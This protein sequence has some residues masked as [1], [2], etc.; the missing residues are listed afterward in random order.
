M[1]AASFTLLSSLSLKAQSPNEL[2]ML[3]AQFSNRPYSLCLHLQAE[4]ARELALNWESNGFS[5]ALD[6]EVQ[7]MQLIVFDD[8]P[9][10]CADLQRLAR[11]LVR[12]QGR[13]LSPTFQSK[14]DR[15]TVQVWQE[16]LGAKRLWILVNDPLE[17]RALLMTLEGAFNLRKAG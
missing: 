13:D 4:Q 14:G 8:Y 12:Q 2:E 3:L 17:E 9:R 5:Q 16:G 1:L 6:G 15:R 10:G 11:T 7:G